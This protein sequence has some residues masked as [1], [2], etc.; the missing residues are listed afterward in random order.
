MAFLLWSDQKIQISKSE[1]QRELMQ[2]FYILWKQYSYPDFQTW[3]VQVK[4]KSDTFWT[5]NL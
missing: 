5:G 3:Q 2:M 4:R 1:F